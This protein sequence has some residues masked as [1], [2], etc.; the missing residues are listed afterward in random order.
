M[1]ALSAILLISVS[2]AVYYWTTDV[3][4]NLGKSLSGTQR[5]IQGKDF[6][7]ILTIKMH[8]RHPVGGKFGR[9]FSAFLI[10]AEL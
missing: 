5:T 3:A 7:V 4:K 1:P 8:T 6:E 10:V 2:T 9:E